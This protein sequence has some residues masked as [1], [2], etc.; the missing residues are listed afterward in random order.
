MTAAERTESYPTEPLEL[1]AHEGRFID[2]A[3]QL[4]GADK[5]LRRLRRKVDRL[6]EENEN[7]RMC[8]NAQKAQNEILRKALA[9]RKDAVKP[10][11]AEEIT[12][13]W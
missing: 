12:K 10:V 9:K 1:V 4:R 5:G 13:Q 3:H 8:H 2:Y 11:T 6:Q 7:L